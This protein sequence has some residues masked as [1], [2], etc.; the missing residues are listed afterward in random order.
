MEHRN[1]SPTSLT[2]KKQYVKP[3]I[4]EV[5]LRPQEAVLA[6]CK[7]SKVAGPGTSACQLKISSCFTVGS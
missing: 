2:I 7:T 5:D 3:E 1:E 4:K 6:F